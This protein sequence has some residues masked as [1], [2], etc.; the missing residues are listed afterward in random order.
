ME[1]PRAVPFE[2]WTDERGQEGFLH[3][4]RADLRPRDL[5]EA[6]RSSNYGSR[7]T[8]AFVYFTG[9]LDAALT[10]GTRRHERSS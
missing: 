2:V 4:T 10:R 3:G 8:A 5:I 7:D 1:K 6:G 9:T